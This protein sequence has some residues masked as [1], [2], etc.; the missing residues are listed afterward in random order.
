VVL[1]LPAV[2]GGERPVGD[3]SNAG[4]GDAVHLIGLFSEEG[5]KIAPDDEPL[6]PF[7]M[8]QTCGSCHSYDKISSGWH[9][10]AHHPGVAP[11]RRGQ[12]WILTDAGTGSQIPVS[13]RR[14]PGTFRPERIGLTSWQFVQLFGQHMPGGGAVS[15]TH[16]TLPTKA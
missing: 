2:A 9:F 16:L 3:E 14:W 12:P 6:L 15:Y 10:N 13:Y 4:Q 5:Q 11:G 1:A 8:R 7:S